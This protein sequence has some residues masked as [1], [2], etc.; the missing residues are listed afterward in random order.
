MDPDTINPQTSTTKR[1]KWE[2]DD[3][4]RNLKKKIIKSRKKENHVYIDGAKS[5]TNLLEK[6]ANGTIEPNYK[7]E[8]VN[9]IPD[10]SES[11]EEDLED[12]ITIISSCRSVDKCYEKL[13]RI[14]EGTY[15]IVYRARD[16][17]TG[18]IVALK[19]LK[20]ANEKNGFPITSLREIYTLLLAK[21][22]NI[23]NVREIVSGSSLNSIYLVMDYIDH[24]LKALIT[25]M[26]S[27]FLQS[28]IKT[29][30]LQLLSA[31]GFLHENW[32]VHR[33]LKTSNLLMNNFGE[34]KVADFGLARKYGSPLGPMTQLVV[35]LWY[36]APELLFG[37]KEYSTAVDMWSIGCIFAELIDKEPLFP[38]RGEIDQIS[39]IF[40][41]L[42]TP[43]E[44]TWPQFSSLPNAKMFTFA[45]QP[46]S[47]LREKFINLTQ[48]GIDLLSRMLEYN[49]K[50]RITA[51]EALD[52]PYFKESPFPKDPSLFPTWPS[53]S[54]G[55][56]RRVY[57]SPS[58]PKIPRD[59]YNDSSNNSGEIPKSDGS[60]NVSSG[61]FGSNGDASTFKLKI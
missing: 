53:K 13:N 32:I 26:P 19:H 35:T 46:R 54:S 50:T 2:L 61:L 36:R 41:L 38:G 30:M 48:N 3:E 56:K 51:Q 49:P 6:Q 1:S 42:G 58:A 52:H 14:E 47:K 59:G 12:N 18:E 27:V 23:V 33:D 57:V 44:N 11:S 7:E 20:L 21:H 39:K 37:E 16:I 43:N 9:T 15:G 34:I 28:E 8:T 45:N 31:V 5:E 40:S 22:P 25:D 10:Y 17:Q 29:L 4:E 55:E 60:R 24:D